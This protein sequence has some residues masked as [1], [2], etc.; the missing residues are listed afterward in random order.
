MTRYSLTLLALTVVATADRFRL[1][2]VGLARLQLLQLRAADRREE[3]SLK[4]H[5]LLHKPN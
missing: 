3:M 2:A 1:M 5:S 4:L